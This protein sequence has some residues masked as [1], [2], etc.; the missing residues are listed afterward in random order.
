[1]KTCNLAEEK[2]VVLIIIPFH[3]QQTVDGGMEVTNPAFRMVN[4]NV[5]A[6]APCSIGILVERRLSGSTYLTSNQA[7]HH[8]AVLFI[9]G[10]YDREALSYAWSVRIHKSLENLIDSG[11]LTVE[12]E[13]KKEKNLDEEHVNEFRI[14]TAHDGSIRYNEKVVN[15][16]GLA[17]WSE[18]TELG[19]IGDLL[20]SSDFAATVLVLVVQQCLGLEPE[21][22]ELGTPHAPA[23]PEE[24]FSSKQIVNRP[25]GQP[26]KE[27]VKSKSLYRLQKL[28]NEPKMSAARQCIVPSLGGNLVFASYADVKNPVSSFTSGQANIATPAIEVKV[29]NLAR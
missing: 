1:M 5:L 2:L 28:E 20:A 26:F 15:N 29:L 19:A 25:M 24:Q 18:C 8:I 3:K 4:Q 22:G 12:R 13:N 21:G 16:A 17:D 6:K 7:S 23:Q 10:T 9:G 14:Q 11:M 27:M